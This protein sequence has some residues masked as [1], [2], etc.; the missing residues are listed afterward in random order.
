MVKAKLYDSTS[1]QLA[2]M[3]YTNGMRPEI[4]VE[5]ATLKELMLYHMMGDHLMLLFWLH[6]HLLCRGVKCRE[7]RLT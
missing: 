6:V 1:L 4:L 3:T 7:A 2:A 5:H